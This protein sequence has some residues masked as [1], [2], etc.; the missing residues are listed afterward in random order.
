[1]LI[2]YTGRKTGRHYRQPVSYVR[3]GGPARI[4]L[5]GR[6]V[7]ARPELVRDPAEVERLLGVIAAKN[8]RAARFVPIHRGGPSPVH[9][10]PARAPARPAAQPSR[11][12]A[13]QVAR[14]IELL[15]QPGGVDAGLALGSEQVGLVLELP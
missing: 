5:R 9:G 14:H 8:P 2:H 7:T 15:A 6:D 12:S 4:R 13:D 3:D 10:L 1:M 11:R